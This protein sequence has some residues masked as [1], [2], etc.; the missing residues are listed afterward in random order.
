[1]LSKGF[2]CIAFHARYSYCLVRPL[3]IMTSSSLPRSSIPSIVS[4]TSSTESPNPD[5]TRIPIGVPCGRTRKPA[6]RTWL[7]SLSSVLDLEYRDIDTSTESV[8]DPLSS[9]TSPSSFVSATAGNDNPVDESG[10]LRAYTVVVLIV[11]IIS[12]RSLTFILF[13]IALVCMFKDPLL[14]FDCKSGGC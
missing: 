9:P 13:N 10:T 4:T 14:S 2:T 5:D 8:T 6:L 11:K 3:K 12:D 7:P 1:M